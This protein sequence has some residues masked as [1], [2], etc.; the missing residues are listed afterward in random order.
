MRDDDLLRWVN[1]IVFEQYEYSGQC[2]RN[3]TDLTRYIF[4]HARFDLMAKAVYAEAFVKSRVSA[5]ERLSYLEHI[6]AFN[7]FDEGDKTGKRGEAAFLQAFHRLLSASAPASPSALNVIPINEDGMA[8]DGSHRLARAY[9][10]NEPVHLLQFRDRTNVVFDHG[11]FKSRNIDRAV[12]DSI[13][14]NYA[15]RNPLSQ[16]FLFFPRATERVV[17]IESLL[18]RFVDIFYRKDICWTER[19]PHNV[20]AALYY[21]EDWL[22][23]FA[24]GFCGARDK[25][26]R[27]FSSRH[28]LQF[29]VTNGKA[30]DEITK[31]KRAIRD[32]LGAE[33][34]SMHSSSSENEKRAMIGLF[35]NENSVDW[36]NSAWA[37]Y[38][39]R[40]ASLFS[41]Y[42]AQNRSSP[43]NCL[44]G[45]A[46]YAAYGIRDVM[47]LDC[48]SSDAENAPSGTDLQTA[49]F[50]GLISPLSSAEVLRDPRFHFYYFGE[51][52][53][54]LSI[55]HRLKVR[56]RESKDLRDA[57]LFAWAVI[58]NRWRDFVSALARKAKRGWRWIRAGVRPPRNPANTRTAPAGVVVQ[59]DCDDA[60]AR[61]RDS[62]EGRGAPGSANVGSALMR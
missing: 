4:H 11:F 15:A 5:W 29:Y 30:P 1:P 18:R 51:K 56:R 43:E 31:I 55:Y 7:N 27:C 8:I 62:A 2:V 25:Y 17:D 12:A 46:A 41:R 13:A 59:A 53:V 20:T 47:D 34:H 35:L 61:P 16:C 57:V 23:S 26:S 48:I 52:V 33:N 21:G 40:F 60:A 58:W 44:V 28:P 22:G 14:F 19:A 39:S 10:R 49:Y 24:D 42:A 9:V 32:I 45:S 36:L 6:R 54:A 3:V 50:D 37:R 38:P